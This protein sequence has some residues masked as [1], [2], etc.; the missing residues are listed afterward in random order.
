MKI[1]VLTGLLGFLAVTGAFAHSGA[2][3]VVL[4]RMEMMKDI[5]DQMKI[6]V[7]MIRGEEEYDAA[8]AQAAAQAI[9]AHAQELT[10]KF[11]EGSIG[12][13]SEALPAIWENWDD[14]V[15]QTEQLHATAIALSDQAASADGADGLREE[16]A[17]VGQTCSS[18]HQDFRKA[19]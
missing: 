17:A 19:N 11:P 9:A 6:I 8:K 13:P 16:I 5:S 1:R 2:S 12:H 14:F 3:G 4:E 15:E 10:E 18:C 7:T